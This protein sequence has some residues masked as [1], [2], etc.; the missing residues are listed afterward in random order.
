MKEMIR[1]ANQ[2]DVQS[3][4]ELNVIVQKLH[5]EHV[6]T[7]IKM[8]SDNSDFLAWVGGV[9]LDPTAYVLIAE[10]SGSVAGYLYAQEV[11]KDESWVRPELHY[12]MLHHI[13]IKPEHQR[14]GLGDSLMKALMEEASKRSL[15]RIELDVWHFND[16]ARKFFARYG[17]ATFNKRM[18]VVLK[19]EAADSVNPTSSA[20]DK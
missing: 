2:S 19:E 6:P 12:M 4:W 8:P 17:F 18:D 3:I 13:V 10:L 20:K 15:K 7:L 1:A 11:K 5:A 14:K 16:K 9:I